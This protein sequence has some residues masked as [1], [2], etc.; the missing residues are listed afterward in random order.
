MES[1]G[2]TVLVIEDEKSLM[3]LLS[4]KLTQNGFKVKAAC[5]GE[6]GL[7]FALETHPNII[8]LDILLPKIDGLTMLSKLRED[9]WGKTANVIIMTNVN[10]PKVENMALKGGIS[11][12]FIKKDWTLEEIVEKVKEKI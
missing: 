8:L 7:K 11:Y 3:E 9:P 5:D 6:E 1:L 4:L 2:K 10:D 12:Y